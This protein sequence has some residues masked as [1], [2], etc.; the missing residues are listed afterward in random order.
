M[1]REKSLIKNTIVLSIGTVIP[2]FASFIVLPILTGYLTKTEYGTYD[3]ITVLCSLFLPAVTLQIQ[4]AAFRFLIEKKDD[5]DG[6]KTIITNILS[7]L[8]PVSIIAIIVLFIVLNKYLLIEKILIG[9]YFFADMIFCVC[10]QIARGL[11]KNKVYAEASIVCSMANLL[12]VIVLIY[13]FK[14]GFV[15]VLICMLF[16]SLIPSLVMI[17]QLKL[18]RY[19]NFKFLDK[20][21]LK[22]LL[23]YSWPMVPNAMSMWVM[24]ASDRIVVSYFL[25]IE[26]NAIYAVAKKIPNIVTIAQSTFTM[27]W[28]ESASLAANDKDSSEYYSKMFDVIFCMM[29]G[30]MVCILAAMPILFKILIRGNYESAYYQMPI[31]VLGMF[32]YGL[33]SYLGGIYVAVKET[34]SVGM[35]TFLAAIINLITSLLMIK[36][37]G[38]YAASIS[39]LIS[40]IFLAIYRMKDIK[41]H[42]KI[43]YNLKKVICIFIILIIIS[44]C[45]Y[46]K[47]IYVYV[48]EV[49]ISIL[50]T[51][52]LNRNLIFSVLKSVQNRKNIKK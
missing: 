15:G 39:T 5:E 14:M 31:L 51:V 37:I 19:I 34:K 21:C 29:T 7:F 30:I 40:Y 10:G 26:A 24:N 49:V 27:A 43:E 6:K 35:T 47:K 44:V 20:K 2:K 28:Q 41:K 38:I 11:Q 33:A 36:G 12:F 32:F 13:F 17:Y 23:K 52:F 50:V 45:S 3:L 4:T 46:S 16:S 42:V 25:G 9:L 1:S 8:M 18:W 22:E 48:F